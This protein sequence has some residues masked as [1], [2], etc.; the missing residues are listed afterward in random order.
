MTA[1]TL[2]IL[3]RVLHIVSSTVWAGFAIVAGLVLV[4]TAG[5]LKAE[6]ARRMRQSAI[7]RA[8]R[9]VAPAAIISL[10]SGIYLFSTLHTGQRSPTEI[11]LGIGAL[12]AVLSFFV[13][14]IGSGGPERQLARLDAQSTRSPSESAQVEALDRRVVLAGRAT[15]TLLL[16]SG[17]AMAIAR[18]L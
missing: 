9:A 14:A 8:S 12:L 7:S 13:G 16:I 1:F 11:A 17:A 10:L 3:A 2:I 4:N 15:A 5:T 6:E 18:F